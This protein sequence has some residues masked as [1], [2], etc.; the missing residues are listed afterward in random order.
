LLSV[1]LLAGCGR[2][3]FDRLDDA[4]GSS[5]GVTDAAT[6][7]AWTKPF[8]QRLV[9]P[10]SSTTTFTASAAAAGD[11][12]VIQLECYDPTNVPTAVAI[13]APGWMFASLGPLVGSP[14]TLLY[15]QSFGAI[16][17]GTMPATF[18]VHWTTA[19]CGNGDVLLGDERI[20]EPWGLVRAHS[21]DH[22]AALI[23]M[24]VS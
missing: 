22:Q 10:G 7:I 15:A 14:S 21:S 13:S 24:S 19:T 18:M 4:A 6:A 9:Q 17:P 1:A 5:V 20:H 23:A 8:V 12:I 11:A 2:V 16:A 3:G